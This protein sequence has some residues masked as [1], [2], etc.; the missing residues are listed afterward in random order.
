MVLARRGF[1]QTLM[2]APFAAR[3]AAAEAAALAGVSTSGLMPGGLADTPQ[4]PTGNYPEA[5]P[6]NMY[7]DVAKALG[8]PAA[9]ADI[10]SLVFERG[11]HVAAID[12]DL[13]V[14]RSFSLN[15]KI[16][17]QRQR[18]VALELESMQGNYIWRR[19]DERI[20]R[21]LNFFC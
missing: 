14:Y 11:R 13:A 5:T 10:E 9:R 15:A 20:S 8:N 17:F 2:A 21:A 6:A 19:L 7:A 18:N 1:L 3:A 16:A 12:P 4:Q